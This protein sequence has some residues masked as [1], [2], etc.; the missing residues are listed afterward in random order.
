MFRKTRDS[1]VDRVSQ[2]HIAGPS[3]RDSL[4]AVNW[5]LKQGYGIILSP[6]AP[7]SY[8]VSEMIR[9]C[10][11]CLEVMDK[12][13]EV[14]TLRKTQQRVTPV[15]SVKLN[16]LGFD[17]SAVL[18]LFQHAVEKKIRLHVDSLSPELAPETFQMLERL[19]SSRPN[20]FDKASVKN[21][22]LSNGK[23]S[24]WISP[25]GVTIPS[26]WTRSRDDIQRAVEMGLSVRIVKGQWEDPVRPVDPLE[27]ALT[28]ISSIP[29]LPAQTRKK[30]SA[31]SIATHDLHFLKETLKRLQQHYLPYDI[32]QFFSLPLNGTG[33]AEEFEVPFSLYIAYGSPALPYNIR[34]S[35]TRPRL[36]LWM[37]SDYLL[38]KKRVWEIA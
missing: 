22:H 12:G 6:W 19:T 33:L 16:A 35:A 8:S 17:R 15:L 25:L 27:N 21:G 5:T 11:A 1:I 13:R 34:F 24:S 20:T 37:A 9:E 31:I 4:P 38:P 23:N 32:E 30:S 28:I 7:S 2:R 26:R 3:I 14:M 10:E 18:D 29:H 36:A